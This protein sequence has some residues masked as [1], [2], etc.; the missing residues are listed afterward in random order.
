MKKKIYKSHAKWS[1]IGES[2]DTH[3]S[4]ESAQNV[5]NIL[6]STWGKKNPPCPIRGTVLKTWT[7]SEEV[8]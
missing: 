3:K 2:S 1:K 8:S 6:E 7:S 4:Q 5:C